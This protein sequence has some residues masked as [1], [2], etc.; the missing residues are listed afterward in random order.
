VLSIYMYHPVQLVFVDVGN[1]IG[2][3]HLFAN[4]AKTVY[5]F[6]NLPNQ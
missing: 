4:L 2:I 1:K 5:S 3:N 6:Y